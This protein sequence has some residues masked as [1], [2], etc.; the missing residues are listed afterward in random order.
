MRRKKMSDDTL[1]IQERI[2]RGKRIKY[3]REEELKMT[4]TMLAKK[5]GISSQFLGLVEDGKGNLMYKS[6]KKLK[7][8]SRTFFR[9]YLIWIR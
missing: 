5:L 3:I 8:V 4:K 2:D 7:D 1:E 9:L 6:L